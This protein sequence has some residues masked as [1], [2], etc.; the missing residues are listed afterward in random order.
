MS[1]FPQTLRTWRKA[2]RFSQLDLA[3]EAQVSSRHVSFLETGRA[4]PSRDMVARL[5]DALQLPLDA[6]NLM[7][8]HA[9]FA[10]RYRRRGWDSAEMLPIRKAVDRLLMNHMPFPGI[11][12]D[13]LWTIRNANP[14]ALAIYGQFGFGIGD[15]ILDLMMS[16]VL[17]SVVENWPEVA[18]HSLVR[19]R[20]ESLAQGGVAEFDRV[21]E[22]LQRVAKPSGAALGP[23]VP[24]IL[25]QGERR[26]SLFATISQFGTPADV[27]LDD[28]KVELFVPMDEETEAYFQA[29]AA[30]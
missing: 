3:M 20:T 15:S 18:Q 19:L 13:R 17:P 4:Q 30:S 24:A 7:L 14:T 23:V 25:R 28:M 16:E 1:S 21:A 10:A 5:S 2:R 12:V 22:H 9:G 29:L 6:R 26:L 27:A 8:A 11:A